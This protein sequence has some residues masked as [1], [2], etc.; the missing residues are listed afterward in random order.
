TLIGGGDVDLLDRSGTLQNP[1]AA[2]ITGTS[3][4][5]VLENV[6]NTIGGFGQIGEAKLSIVNRAGGQIQATQG[7]LT[8]D[9]GPVGGG[10]SIVNQGVL[11]AVGFGNLVITGEVA[12]AGGSI[13]IGT[14]GCS[15]RLH[16]AAISGG[17]LDG[18]GDGIQVDSAGT[19]LDGTQDAV[20][21][22]R[23]VSVPPDA[24]LSLRGAIENKGTLALE[25]GHSVLSVSGTVTLSGGGTLAL[26][27]ADAAVAGASPPA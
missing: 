10:G 26:S 21:I 11:R 2:S 20:A 18:F 16:G 23:V 9:T 13:A 17:K 8:L 24:T 5:D 27:G 25:G 1:A 7:T 3:T 4:A 15:I 14:E 19:L 12:N 22:T 6:D